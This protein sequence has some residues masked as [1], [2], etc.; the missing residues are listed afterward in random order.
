VS[1]QMSLR[2]RQKAAQREGLR[3]V[4]IDAFLRQGFDEANISEIAQSAG[5]SERTFYRYF[6]TKELVALDWIDETAITVHEVLRRLPLGMSPSEALAEAFIA[7]AQEVR[8]TSTHSRVLPVIFS[9]PRLL[10]A[11][12]EH[13][14]GWADAVAEV[15]AERLGTTVAD[16][17]RPRLWSTIAFTIATQVTQER[18]GREDLV[19]Y[20]TLLRTRFRQAGEFFHPPA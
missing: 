1:V 3:L 13:S 17:P 14:R 12:L 5:V 11:Y 10:N 9:T 18:I 6:P 4:A 19:D 16:D 15:L 8:E 2:E 7:V 20:P